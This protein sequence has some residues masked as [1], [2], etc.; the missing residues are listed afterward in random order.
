MLQDAESPATP[1]TA[2]TTYFEQC[3]CT[4][5][6]SKG[7][8]SVLVPEFVIYDNAC[9]LQTYALMREPYLYKDVVFMVDRLH[10]CNHKNCSCA[11]DAKLFPRDLGSLNSQVCEQAHKQMRK[12]VS[13]LSYMSQTHFMEFM[14]YFVFC[15]NFM[16]DHGQ[17]VVQQIS[18]RTA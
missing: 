14:R 3:T 2:L 11:F 12:L 9:N 13:S 4:D 5:T 10:Y 1:F 8:R 6:V 7:S 16:N 17:T 18:L 15:S